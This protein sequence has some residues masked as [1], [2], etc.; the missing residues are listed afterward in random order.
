MALRRDLQR[1]RV[2]GGSMPK[3]GSRSRWRR[4]RECRI[5]ARGPYEARVYAGGL[6]GSAMALRMGMAATA[7]RCCSCRCPSCSSSCSSCWTLSSLSPLLSCSTTCSGPADDPTRQ[8]ASLPWHYSSEHHHILG[9]PR[10]AQL[11]RVLPLPLTFPGPSPPPHLSSSPFLLL[12]TSLHHAPP[13]PLPRRLMS[14]LPRGTGSVRSP[15]SRTHAITAHRTPSP[16]E[17]T[18]AHRGRTL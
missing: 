13:P 3:R 14:S 9:P 4:T 17:Q 18:S 5:P 1:S 7:S 6:G 12:L 10:C 8:N 16:T 11:L 2:A 15:G